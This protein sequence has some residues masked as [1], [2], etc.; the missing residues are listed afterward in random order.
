MDPDAALDE[1]LA[2]LDLMADLADARIGEPIDRGKILR[3]LV[4]HTAPGS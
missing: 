4:V 3:T 2:L 1:L